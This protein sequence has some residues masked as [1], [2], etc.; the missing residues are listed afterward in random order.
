MMHLT[1]RAAAGFVRQNSG[2]NQNANRPISGNE[3]L[4]RN[5]LHVFRG[6]LV[7]I[8]QVLIDHPIVAEH[9]VEPK[10][11]RLFENRILPEDKASL[12]E[13]F[14]FLQLFGR[15]WLRAQFLELSIY[16]SERILG[17]DARAHLTRDPE[18]IRIE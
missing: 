10:L 7:D 13:I 5:P 16:L 18:Q 12:F 17:F 2:R 4:L 11:H 6:Y 8:R 3:I 15:Y 14:G 1:A 9:L